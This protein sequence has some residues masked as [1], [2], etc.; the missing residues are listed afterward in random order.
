V[1]ITGRSKSFLV[2]F[3]FGLGSLI[4]FLARVIAKPSRI[5]YPCMRAAAPMASAFLSWIIGGGIALFFMKR[6]RY[7]FGQTRIVIAIGCLIV[8]AI[9][10]AV[11]FSSNSRPLF[12]AINFQQTA[13]NTP[14]GTAKGVNP[15]RVVWVH[16]AN[17]TNWKGL[18]DGHWWESSHTNQTVVD[19]MMSRALQ[20]LSGKTSDAEAW[21]SFFRYF[22]TTHN[23][24]NAGYAAGEKIMIKINL[25]GC[26][27]IPGWGGVDA[28]T[29]RFFGKFDYMHASPQ[30]MRALLRQLVNVAGVAQADITMGDPT[31]FFPSEFYDTLHAEFP[32]VHY[33]DCKGG[34][35]RTLAEVSTVP[36]YF[37][38]RPQ[39]KT[40]DYAPKSYVEA[41]Y[42]INLANFKSHGYAAV[43]LGAKNHFGSLVRLPT[44]SGYYVLHESLA[45]FNPVMGKYRVLVDL[46]GHAHLGGKTLLS[47]IDALYGGT[48]PVDTIPLKW[49]VA[50]FNNDWTSS[51]F[52]SQDPV[53]LESVGYDL[54]QLE[55]N[56]QS[57]F[58]KMAAGEDY[59]I[60]A[61]KAD[62]PPSGT[63]YD[64]DHA[65]AFTRLQ[66]LGVHER[67]NNDVDRKY[68]R[69]L[70]TGNGI[71]LITVEGVATVIHDRGNPASHSSAIQL[72]KAPGMR[73][74]TVSMPEGNPISLTVYDALG[75]YIGTAVNGYMAAGV[76]TIDWTKAAGSG[77]LPRGSYLLRATSPKGKV[78]QKVTYT[79]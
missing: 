8:G 63:F 68:T 25:V 40:Q 49:K 44:Q 73:F 64:P 75:K 22:N 21:N 61:A 72:E 47:I 11:L 53:A 37:S 66:S 9:V 24:G 13:P 52:A 43:T 23:R 4:W 78:A 5:N 58:P 71:E 6:A 14:I 12:A 74:V 48:H 3:I 19:L 29:Y 33:L 45:S 10:S 18:G 42:F 35:G 54:M 34:S 28:N 41:T 65:T 32:N 67:W 56:P 69:N 59:L 27:N 55:G 50:P 2:F 79:E 31:A 46:L 70:S 26:A 51:V 17:S 76:Y 39:G 16:D 62:N 7:Y 38:C 60:E 30:M 36:V 77:M 20:S 57:S 15:G 1:R